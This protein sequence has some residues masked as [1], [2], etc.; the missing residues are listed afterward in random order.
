M[1][2][3]YTPM[4]KSVRIPMSLVER[5]MERVDMLKGMKLES[6]SY[7]GWCLYLR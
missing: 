4:P 6:D 1:A 3:V 5:I 7:L 2:P